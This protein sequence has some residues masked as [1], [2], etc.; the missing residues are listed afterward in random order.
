[1]FTATLPLRKSIRSCPEHL[2][3]DEESRGTEYAAVHGTCVAAL[4]AFLGALISGQ[5]NR[6]CASEGLPGQAW[7]AVAGS[8]MFSESTRWR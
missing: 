1:L 5:R 7:A 4:S 8:F 6:A 3:A 2:I